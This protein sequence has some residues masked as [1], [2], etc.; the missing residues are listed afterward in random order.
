M[1]ISLSVPAY[2]YSA[3]GPALNTPDLPNVCLRNV[4]ICVL[5]L[6][7]LVFLSFVAAVRVPLNTQVCRC[8]H[9]RLLTCFCLGVPTQNYL[10]LMG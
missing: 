5:T 2:F 9:V 8:Q 3:F 7:K 1:M 10:C 4:M 6:T